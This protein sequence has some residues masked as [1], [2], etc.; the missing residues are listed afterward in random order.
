MRRRE[1]QDQSGVN[2]SLP[3][4]DLLKRD[5]NQESTPAATDIFVWSVYT[6]SLSPWLPNMISN[7]L[8]H[9]H[10]LENVAGDLST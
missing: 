10:P 7:L 9:C 3:P 2:D 4:L 5:A 1:E 8:V 6:G